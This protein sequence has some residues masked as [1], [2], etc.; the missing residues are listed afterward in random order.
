MS[1]APCPRGRGL[2]VSRLC[3]TPKIIVGS[4]VRRSPGNQD[5]LST[6]LPHLRPGSAQLQATEKQ[7]PRDGTAFVGGGDA[8]LERTGKRKCATPLN[9]PAPGCRG[10]GAAYFVF[11]LPGVG[12]SLW[13]SSDGLRRPQALDLLVSVADSAD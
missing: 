11:R 6:G 12:L 9:V 3:P 10:E 5:G 13:L 1:V 8:F 2:C 4:K 7:V